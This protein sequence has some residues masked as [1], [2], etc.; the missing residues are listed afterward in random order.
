MWLL[1]AQQNFAA[2]SGQKTH[3]L[4]MMTHAGHH[5]VHSKIL[6]LYADT[7]DPNKEA[8]KRRYLWRQE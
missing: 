1:P 6:A 3:A 5:K 8:E 7:E 2:I 4:A